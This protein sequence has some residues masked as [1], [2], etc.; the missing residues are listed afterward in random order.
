MAILVVFGMRYRARKNDETWQVSGQMSTLSGT[1]DCPLSNLL[2]IFAQVSMDELHFDD[3]VEVVGQGSFGVVWL[4]STVE[5]RL[6]SSEPSRTKPSPSI[7]REVEV[8]LVRT[9]LEIP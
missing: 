8:V 3:P 6:Q 9:K 7:P 4:A 5:Q 2:S 1:A